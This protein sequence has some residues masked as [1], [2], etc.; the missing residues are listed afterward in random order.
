MLFR[1]LPPFPWKIP[2]S[3]LFLPSPPVLKDR[4][5]SL[6]LPICSISFSRLSYI[7]FGI[8]ILKD[9][10]RPFPFTAFLKQ[11]THGQRYAP[12]PFFLPVTSMEIR[13][14]VSFRTRI[15][16]FLFFISPQPIHCLCGIFFSVLT[17][18]HLSLFSGSAAAINC[19][20]ASSV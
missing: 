7:S 5:L 18:S 17:E 14:S 15:N 16:S 11:S 3:V 4:R 8:A 13:P 9:R 1:I 19:Y 12:R 10:S 6:Y 20:S 2:R